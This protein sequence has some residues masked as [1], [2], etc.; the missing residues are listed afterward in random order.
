MTSSKAE[1]VACNEISN[2]VQIAAC[3]HLM[4]KLCKN[5]QNAAWCHAHDIC[6]KCSGSVLREICSVCYCFIC[7]RC[8][9]PSVE[10]DYIVTCLQPGCNVV[11]CKPCWQRAFYLVPFTFDARQ[12]WKCPQHRKN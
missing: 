8:A 2:T 4:C 11:V 3:G 1:C 5:L 9:T 6:P 10:Q 12:Q 7:K